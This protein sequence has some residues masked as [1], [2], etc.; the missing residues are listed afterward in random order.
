MLTIGAYVCIWTHLLL[1]LCTPALAQSTNETA[2]PEYSPNS[3]FS[4]PS[5][6][7]Y[8]SPS[9]ITTP[10]SAKISVA[11]YSSPST[12][13]SRTINYITHTLAQQCL[14]TS[15]SQSTKASLADASAGTLAIPWWGEGTSDQPKDAESAS[16]TPGIIQSSSA[17]EVGS[18]SSSHSDPQ[19]TEDAS[20]SPFP[21]GTASTESEVE[22]D[23]PLDNAHFLSFEE[24]K[25]Q[26]LVRAGQSPDNVGQG[27]GT[28]GGSGGRRRPVDINNALDSLGEDAEFELDFGGFGDAGRRDDGTASWAS[29]TR[30]R[31]EASK[32]ADDGGSVPPSSRARSKDAGKTC[33]E[34]FNYASFD[35]AATVLKTN[36]QCKSSSSVLVEN[37]DSY[38]LNECAAENK[39]IIVELCDD[40]LIDTIVL[41]NFEFFSSMFRT[42][43]I[44]V[45]DRYPVKLDR[46]KELGTFEAR[47]S[48][49]I[50]AFLIENPLI[51]ARY[52][53]VEFLSHYGNEYYCPV[54]LLRVHGTTMMEEFRHQEEAARGEDDYSEPIEEAEGEPVTT[55]IPVNEES[56]TS[57]IPG[58]SSD[59]TSQQPLP[60]A[61]QNKENVSQPSDQQSPQGQPPEP[62]PVQTNAETFPNESVVISQPAHSGNDSEMTASE[63][64]SVTTSHSGVFSPLKEERSSAPSGMVDIPN[65]NETATASSNSSSKIVISPSSSVQVAT[66]S[67]TISISNIA[68]KPA[69]NHASTVSSSSAP[70]TKS[71]PSSSEQSS[72]HSHSR[73][74]SSQTQPAPANPTTQESFFKSIHKRLQQLE[75][76]STLSLQYIEEQSRILRDAFIKVEKRQLGKTETFLQ[77]INSTVMAELK[78]YRMQY[79]QLWQSTILELESHREQYQREIG[80]IGARLTLLA[81][82]L[83]FQKRMAVVQSTMLLLCLGLV[84]FVR[85]GTLGS[86]LDVPI[87]QQMMGSA[88]QQFGKRIFDTPP[89]SPQSGRRGGRF[90]SMWRSDTAGSGSGGGHLSDPGYEAGRGHLSSDAETDGNR[91]P[92]RLEFE[93]PTPTSAGSEVG[94]GVV[95]GARERERSGS[96]DILE[97]G[98][99]PRVLATQSGPATPRGSRDMKPS[100]EEMDKSGEMLKV[101]EEG[102]GLR[103]RSP[104]RRSESMGDEDNS[105]GRDQF[106][107]NVGRDDGDESGPGEDEGGLM[108]FE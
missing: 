82:E 103:K 20:Q 92:I 61:S 13:Q 42:F 94:N 49:D 34:R 38:M 106:D 26:N 87:V 14:K 1:F 76:N 17:G 25:K 30:E 24:W 57:G 66:T 29:G 12:C 53:R 70:S 99:R 64:Q 59:Q 22:T 46:W 60:E 6:S 52:L 16:R 39:F 108:E 97:D 81:D 105:D 19:Q 62:E 75:S 3:F 21:S 102:L 56:A 85:S 96:D 91:S 84:L 86:Q 104:L 31:H 27:R 9:S 35:C 32:T 68:V 77:N 33:K 45:S 4:I 36:P 83:V 71:S 54:S 40:I 88:Q 101:G 23:S 43:R 72:T 47:N 98:E 90:R 18:I 2:G 78:S 107:E 63:Q 67:N 28:S 5:A 95:G 8:L 93:P 55:A 41:A 89:G 58:T 50:Q 65:F 51:W 37:K 100:W 11:T 69:T 48:R 79:D 73:P 15:W 7:I 44:S 80:E 10:T 74:S